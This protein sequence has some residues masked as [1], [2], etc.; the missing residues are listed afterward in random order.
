MATNKLQKLLDQLEGK[1]PFGNK[2]GFEIRADI[3]KLA[4]DHLQTE[5]SYAQSQ[6]EQSITNPKW[7]GGTV[8]KP[9]YPNTHKVLGT[10][11]EMYTFV[12]TQV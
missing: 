10:A 2:N 11:K 9:V 7:K 6:Y 4:Q 5:F 3:L 8:A 1:S 12:N